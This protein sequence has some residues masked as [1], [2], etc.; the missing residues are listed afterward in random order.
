[1]KPDAHGRRRSGVEVK[2][3]FFYKRFAGEVNRLSKYSGA[4]VEE[5]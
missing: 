5:R 2:R 1:M 4:S 3:L